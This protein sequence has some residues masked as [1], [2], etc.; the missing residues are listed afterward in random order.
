MTNKNDKW[1]IGYELPNDNTIILS[2]FNARV[3][4][5]STQIDST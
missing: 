5:N 1:Y 3:E 2:D 4:E